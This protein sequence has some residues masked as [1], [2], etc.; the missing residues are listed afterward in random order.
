MKKN[1]KKCIGLADPDSLRCHIV[2]G[3]VRDISTL[4]PN[5]QQVLMI[6]EIEN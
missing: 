5:I 6:C 1:T 4:V 3:D 2:A